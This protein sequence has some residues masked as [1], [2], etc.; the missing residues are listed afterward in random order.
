MSGPGLVRRST[1]SRRASRLF[2]ALVGA[3]SFFAAAI[4]SPAAAATNTLVFADG[5]VGSDGVYTVSVPFN[6]STPTY[7]VVV[8]DTANA[9]AV[10][11]TSVTTVGTAN[12]SLNSSTG[13]LTY[14]SAGS[15]VVTASDQ[16]DKDNGQGVG[17][18]NGNGQTSTL[19]VTVAPLIN[20]TIT[21]TNTPPSSPSVGSSYTVT[22]NGG[23]SGNPVTFSVDASSSSGCTVNSTT[24]LVTLSAPAGT[25]V[26]DANQAGNATYAPAPQVSQTVSSSLINQTITITNSNPDTVE[27]GSVSTYQIHA[28]PSGGGTLTY[29]TSSSSCAVNAAGTITNLAIGRCVIEVGATANGTFSAA[30]PVNFTL[31]VIS[32][33][34]TVTIPSTPPPVVV[35]PVTPPPV[36]TPVSPPP[37][38]VI[39]VSPPKPPN[40]PKPKPKPTHKKV[41]PPAPRPAPSIRTIVI[42]PFA[43]GS[44]SLSKSLR[45]QVWRLAELI[46][47]LRYHSV[48]LAGYT[49]NVF[50]PALDA[51]LIQSRAEAVKVQLAADFAALRVRGVQVSVVQGLSIQL[52]SLNATVKS[53]ALNRRVVATLRAR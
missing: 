22:A 41:V 50:T 35:P 49:D 25:C 52:V 14:S 12:C 27:F 28:T 5:A 8:S 39:P 10:I 46:K 29:V 40:K 7:Q 24:G 15:C 53:R 6:A 26:I 16:S 4:A 3:S 31:N 44:W 34:I 33:P 36:V 18:G 9:S 17:D 1:G 38:I 48:T 43:Q 11:T 19:T 2:V 20:Q 45:A 51:V 47:R 32:P 23:G 13:V 21:F 42:R 30:T 37:P